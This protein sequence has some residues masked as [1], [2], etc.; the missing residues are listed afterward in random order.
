MIYLFLGSD[1][2]SRERAIHVIAKQHQR[3]LVRHGSGELP[4]H[5]VLF[6][7]DLFAKPSLHVIQNC[8]SDAGAI[9]HVLE[10]GAKSDAH[11]IWIEEKLDKRKKEV[12]S[13]LSDKRI[14]VKEFVMPQGR[15]L[16]DWISE[17][18][19]NVGLSLSKDL[20]NEVRDRIVGVSQGGFGQ[21]ISYSLWDIYN[22]LEKLSL[23]SGGEPLTQEAIDA[24]VPEQFDTPV[25]D[26]VNA[27]ADKRTT[28]AFL[29]LQ[30]FLQ[31]NDSTDQ[32]A[33]TIQLAAL[34]SDQFR[35][36]ALVQ[37]AG[38]ESIPE[39]QIVADT[40]WKSGRLFILKKI[41]A[42]FDP[43]KVL[44]TLQKFASFDVEVK[45]SQAPATTLLE[46]IIAQAI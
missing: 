1:D 2:F 16:D 40:G 19:K 33:K 21:E 20:Q 17:Q 44:S 14:V 31:S 38:R 8:F 32:K 46:L 15:E 11:L 10:Q 3:D 43:H 4:S 41:S 30:K 9:E 29:H 37:A 36:I 25:W 23:W 22:A 45:S 42:K 6:G 13:L 26:I 18:A 28:D 5:A 24:L 35:S 27:I 12:K 34:L 39:A 7:A